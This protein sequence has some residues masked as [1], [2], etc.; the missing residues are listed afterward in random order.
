MQKCSKATFPSFDIQGHSRSTDKEDRGIQVHE[1]VLLLQRV[2]EARYLKPWSFF[3]PFSGGHK[4]QKQLDKWK[5][6]DDEQSQSV[7]QP[8]SPF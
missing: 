3:S 4:K 7:Q 6:S 8:K 2:L 1:N 5:S